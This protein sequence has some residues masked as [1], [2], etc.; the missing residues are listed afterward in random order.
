MASARERIGFVVRRER[1]DQAVAAI[2]A[3]E[4][5]GLG[6]A[7]MIMIGTGKDTPT[8]F[9]AA[10][11]ATSRVKLGTGIVPAFTRHPI[12][13]ASQALTLNDLAP[14]RLRLGIGT[15]HAPTMRDALGL[16]F[17]RPLERL[18]EYVEVLRPALQSGFVHFVGEFY[19]VDTRMVAAAP[20]IPVLIAALRE[21]AYEL[22]GA[23]TDGAISWL[24]PV[25]YL[26]R[27]AKPALE[28]GAAA[29][30]R[31]V[32]PLIA[33]I[34][35]MPEANRARARVAARQALGRY[36]QLPFY[37]SMFAAAGYPVGAGGELTDE[38][39]EAIVVSGDDDAIGERLASL[40]GQGLDE[41]MVALIPG[42]DPIGDEAHLL[43]ILSRVQ[44]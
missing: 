15:S 36:G 17:E 11:T 10:A 21:H 9:A 29:A 43:E 42:T 38:L 22:A 24:S 6:T 23:L 2:R 40:L 16:P 14:G 18:R 39:L 31:Q 26:L 33:A 19:R 32:P 41:L 28:R 3:V 1:A 13:L 25:E 30:G 35:V 4:A 20:E 12:G 34:Q 27:T 8:L 37:A 44:L 5:A 7:W